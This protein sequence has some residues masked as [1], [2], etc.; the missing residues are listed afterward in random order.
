MLRTDKDEAVKKVKENLEKAQAIFLTNLVGIEA[1]EAVRVR[2]GVRDANGY[3]IITRNSLFERAAK[4]TYAE[5][6][7]SNLKG[8][9]AVAFA[10]KDAPAVAKVIFEANKENEKVLLKGGVLDGKTLTAAEVVVL[11]KL[12]SRDQM[13]GTL[14][15]TFNAP[16]SAFARVMFAIKEQKEKLTA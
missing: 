11:A 10:F 13:L 3:M 7:L 5:K 8:P 1:N 16:V 14:L 9:S 4:G 2:K 12:P 15:A 6:L